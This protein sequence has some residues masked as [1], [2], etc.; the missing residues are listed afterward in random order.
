[1]RENWPSTLL[2]D[3]RVIQYW[4]DARALGRA[5]LA[6]VPAMLEH[7]A[8]ATL[9]PT[10]DAMWDAY[11]VYA[12]GDAWQNPVPVPVSWGSSDHGHGR[13]ASR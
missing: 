9:P 7:R 5:Y 6:H 4:D 12:P 11:F 8:P 3:P 13:S 2:T 1:M 10:A